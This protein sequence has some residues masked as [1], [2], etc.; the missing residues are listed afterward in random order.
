MAVVRLHGVL[1]EEAGFRELEVD[2]ANLGE[3][4][5]KLPERVR[6]VLGRYSK[7]LVFLVDGR[8]IRDMS[9]PLKRGDVVDV[10]IFV[11]GGWGFG[12]RIVHCLISIP[13]IAPRVRIRLGGARGHPGAPHLW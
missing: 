4:L 2:G 5:Q 13:P 8:V 11:G 9:T 1:R 10:T 7:Y 12:S 6:E 3:V